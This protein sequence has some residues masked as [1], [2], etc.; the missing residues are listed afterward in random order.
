MPPGSGR[1]GR[2]RW[3]PQGKPSRPAK[4][5]LKRLRLGRQTLDQLLA[6]KVRS[7]VSLWPQWQNLFNLEPELVS[8]NLTSTY[9]QGRGP[10]ERAR[11]GYSRDGEPENRPRGWT[12]WRLPPLIEAS[13]A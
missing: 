5:S 10:R 13:C 11:F 12:A 1:A 9:F 8:Y 6:Q 2:R 3:A 4:V 7:E